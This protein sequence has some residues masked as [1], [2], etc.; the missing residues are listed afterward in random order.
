MSDDKSQASQS[1]CKLES[2]SQVDSVSLKP[3][4][5]RLHT[6]PASPSAWGIAGS[7]GEFRKMASSKQMPW[8]SR[9]GF[10]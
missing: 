2:S 10:C 8:R 5:E 1:P 9:A 4:L 6:L 7:G 3:F